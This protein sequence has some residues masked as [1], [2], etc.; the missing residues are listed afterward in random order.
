MSGKQTPVAKFAPSFRSIKLYGDG[1]I[2]YQGQSGSIIG[3]TAR[4]DASGSKRLFRDTREIFLMIEG[5]NVSIAAPLGNK[6]H[7]MQKQAHQFEAKVNELAMRLGES[8]KTAPAKALPAPSAPPKVDVVDQLERLGKLR[9]SGVLTEEEFQAQKSALLPP[10][11][12]G[13]G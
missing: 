1:T 2:E 13:S 9:E 8:T 3:A 10:T 4:V 6:G 7:L 5:P 12:A 11:P